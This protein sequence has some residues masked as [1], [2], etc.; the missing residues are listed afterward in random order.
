MARTFSRRKRSQ[1]SRIRANWN[2]SKR[3]KRFETKLEENPF[4]AA[5]RELLRAAKCPFYARFNW[6]LYAHL[7][8]LRSLLRRD[9]S[10]GSFAKLAGTVIP[11]VGFC[12]R[13][14]VVS[15]AMAGTVRYVDQ[16]QEGATT[17]RER[18]QYS[19]YRLFFARRLKSE[20]HTYSAFRINLNIINKM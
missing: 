16:I 7:D 2:G 13:F 3:R 9:G 19:C 1:L 14:R 5:F 17:S 10:I 15:V 6:S 11:S 12:F 20:I 4:S 18:H 8:I